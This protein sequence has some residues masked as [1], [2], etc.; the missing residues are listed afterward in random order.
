LRFPAHPSFILVC[1][2]ATGTLKLAGKLKESTALLEEVIAG[3]RASQ[4][5][6]DA[7]LC[8]DVAYTIADELNDQKRFLVLRSTAAFPCCLA[9]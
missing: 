3:Y 9:S 2:L 6:A 8:S 7:R 4:P 1:V 5:F